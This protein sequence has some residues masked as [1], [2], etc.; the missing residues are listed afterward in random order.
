MTL[1]WSP[2]THIVWTYGRQHLKLISDHDKI[3]SNI[4]D[5]APKIKRRALAE[6]GL[7]VSIFKCSRVRQQ[8]FFECTDSPK[9]IFLPLRSFS[10]HSNPSKN[11]FLSPPRSFLSSS[12][13]LTD[14]KPSYTFKVPFFPEKYAKKTF[15]IT[16]WALLV[17]QFLTK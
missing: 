1:N 5:F 11:Y 7:K 4:Q 12:F 17:V 15:F 8:F 16:C 10:I 3:Y 13:T 6:Y 14:Q 9:T 2:S